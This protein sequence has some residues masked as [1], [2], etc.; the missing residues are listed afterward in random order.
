MNGCEYRQCNY[1]N[2][3]KG[4]WEDKNEYENENGESV[5]GR[6]EDAILI[7]NKRRYIMD[8]KDVE[9]LMHKLYRLEEHFESKNYIKYF[10]DKEA[11]VSDVIRALNSIGIK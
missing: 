3:E 9:I 4:M 2:K 6:R 8:I 1:W 5:C 10:R 7:K 11:V